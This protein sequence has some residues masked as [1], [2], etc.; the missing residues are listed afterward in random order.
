MAI[1]DI[2][3]SMSSLGL[4]KSHVQ[5]FIATEDQLNKAA[6]VRSACQKLLKRLSGSSGV[7]LFG[8]T[9]QNMSSLRQLEVIQIK[10][11]FFKESVHV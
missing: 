11:L 8:G 7:G 4:Q 9:F 2:F 5:K 6:E 1:Y 10:C 3:C